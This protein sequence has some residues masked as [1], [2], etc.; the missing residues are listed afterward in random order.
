MPEM[1]VVVVDD[2]AMV[3]EYYRSEFRFEEL[4]WRLL[5]TASDGR[6]AVEL[7]R[8]VKPDIVLMDI[9]MPGMDGF[10]ATERIKAFLPD[11][12]I[13]F[14]TCNEDFAYARKALR[15]GAADYVIKA[16]I[17]PL[18]MMELF[19]QT[20]EKIEEKRIRAGEEGELHSLLRSALLN[21]SPSAYQVR[22]RVETLLSQPY[23]IFFIQLHIVGNRESAIRERPGSLRLFS[24]L[25]SPGIGAAKAWT[26]TGTDEY[27]VLLD[28]GTELFEL[29]GL[30]NTL[31]REIGEEIGSA[32]GLSDIRR[33]I[34]EGHQA[35]LQARER[36][37]A[38]FYE[39]SGK[40]YHDLEPWK[41]LSR[42]M[43]S[44][45]K[46]MGQAQVDRTAQ[47]VEQY[48]K[49][50]RRLLEMAKTERLDPD[51]A[52]ALL[53]AELSRLEQT[54]GKEDARWAAS[55]R[56]LQAAAAFTAEQL[57]QWAD[58]TI[59]E[60]FISSGTLK[61]RPQIR[62]VVDAVTLKFSESFEL[63]RAADIAGMHPNYF[64][65]VFK[66]ETGSTFN[67]YLNTLRMHRAAEYI[68]EGVWQLQQVAE[69]VGVPNYRSFFNTFRRIMGMPPSEFARQGSADQGME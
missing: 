33:G 37:R 21:D 48:R 55:L 56:P 29:D 31:G 38:V 40:V 7:C 50:I 46:E 2:E 59:A 66:Q 64:S 28:S 1:G 26:E 52:K 17:T 54:F 45:L 9:T 23:K 11:A 12:E 58:G 43:E 65:A 67:E 20:K 42:E 62:R 18:E 16:S 53:G 39:G 24:K 61:L 49:M 8:N 10:E 4:G 13:L 27:C 68:R 25:M 22:H 6:D 36:S 32:L 51:H 30:V 69:M 35:Y 14:L 44:K 34:A 41:G 47:P 5:G 3:L 60:I 19:R 57:V 15:L 63:N